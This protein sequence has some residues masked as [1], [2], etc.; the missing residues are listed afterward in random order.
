MSVKI[1]LVGKRFGRLVVVKEYKSNTRESQWVCICDCGI[2]TKPILC[3]NL[4]RGHT[5]SCGCIRRERAQKR[6]WKVKHD[7]SHTRL[8]NI[9]QGM[10]QR[11]FNPNNCNY[12]YYGNR[13]ITVCKEWLND[14]ESFR[15]W[16]I[17]NGYRDDLTIDR[18]DVNGN[19]E[20]SNCR[21]ATMKQQANNRRKVG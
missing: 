7:L 8:Y 17:A 16:A 3:S 19:Y 18:I 2:V 5:Q 20:P 1:D 12:K 4:K 15:D 14:F 11:C 10:N 21:W 13:G 9:W 6:T